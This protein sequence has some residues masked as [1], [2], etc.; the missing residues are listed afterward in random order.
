MELWYSFEVLHLHMEGLIQHGLLYAR[1]AAT[2]WIL[3]GDTGA[4]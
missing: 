2:E 4:T 3:L 1:T